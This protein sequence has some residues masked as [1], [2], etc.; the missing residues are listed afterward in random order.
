M[1]SHG[2]RLHVVAA[3]RRG[4]RAEEPPSQRPRHLDQVALVL[5]K[6]RPPRRRRPAGHVDGVDLGLALR[7]WPAHDHAQLDHDVAA[8]QLPRLGGPLTR[9]TSRTSFTPTSPGSSPGTASATACFLAMTP[10]NA[11]PPP[12]ARASLALW[13]TGRNAH[14]MWTTGQLRHGFAH[15]GHETGRCVPRSGTFVTPRA[16][17]YLPVASLTSPNRRRCL[18]APAPRVQREK[19]ADRSASVTV[20]RTSPVRVT[21]SSVCGAAAPLAAT[22]LTSPETSPSRES[23]TTTHPSGWRPTTASTDTCP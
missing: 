19:A 20:P 13:T 5:S 2:H 7:R 18:C 3:L 10:P 8:G 21:A 11:P 17:T 4:A 23:T 6:R 12:R 14:T 16:R 15:L 22:A 9:P 1:S